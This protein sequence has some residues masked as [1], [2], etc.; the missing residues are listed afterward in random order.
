MFE[1][2]SAVGLCFLPR[3]IQE[4]QL[5]PTKRAQCLRAELPIIQ[6]NGFATGKSVY[7]LQGPP[8]HNYFVFSQGI[9]YLDPTTYNLSALSTNLT[10]KF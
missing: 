9:P 10:Q 2:H 4:G 1:K 8:L 6:L 7:S 5:M 3:P